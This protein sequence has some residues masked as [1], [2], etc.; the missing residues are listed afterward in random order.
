VGFPFLSAC[1][2]AGLAW[3]IRAFKKD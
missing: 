2:M 3:A 1:I